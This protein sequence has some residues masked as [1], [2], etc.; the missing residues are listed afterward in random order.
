ME[1]QVTNNMREYRKDQLKQ[2]A[3]EYFEFWAKIKIIKPDGETKW[4]DI[5]ENELKQIKHIL[6]SEI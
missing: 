6:T 1:Q 3:T 5:S 2:V 4:M